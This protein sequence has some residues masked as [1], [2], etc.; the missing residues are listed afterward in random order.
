MSIGPQ[1]LATAPRLA[2][3]CAAVGAAGI[4][5]ATAI[6]AAG[7]GIAN[8]RVVTVGFR[9]PW[10][11]LGIGVVFTL[12]AAWLTLRARGAAASAASAAVVCTPRTCRHTR[13]HRRPISKAR[14]PCR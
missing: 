1:R 13:P 3:A 2:S 14:G 10:T 7:G 6:A 12:A 9:A 11:A 8:L 4:F 5:V